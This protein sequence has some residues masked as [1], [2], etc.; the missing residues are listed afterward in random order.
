MYHSLFI[1]SIPERPLSEQSLVH[2]PSGNIPLL[3]AHDLGG[4]LFSFWGKEK[5]TSMNSKDLMSRIVL[6]YSESKSLITT[7]TKALALLRQKTILSPALTFLQSY[8]VKS[9]KVPGR[10]T[11]T[12]RWGLQFFQACVQRIVEKSTAQ[13]LESYLEVSGTVQIH[14][15]LQNQFNEEI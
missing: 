15:L 11:R 3:E 1:L 14:K 9:F 6:Y 4:C 8:I 13:V 12:Q 7:Y 5:K 2:F 10:G